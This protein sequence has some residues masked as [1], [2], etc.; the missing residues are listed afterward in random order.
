MLPLGAP[1]A[2]QAIHFFHLAIACARGHASAPLLRWHLMSAQKLLLGILFAE[3]GINFVPLDTRFRAA[4]FVEIL[5][6]RAIT[7]HAGMSDVSLPF[8]VSR[9]RGFIRHLK[10]SHSA[11]EDLCVIR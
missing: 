1:D 2:V 4:L 7:H 5:L 3:G 11:V 6:L 10:Y 9:N 8:G